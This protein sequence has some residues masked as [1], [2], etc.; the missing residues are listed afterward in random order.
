MLHVLADRRRIAR[1]VRVLRRRL[2]GLPVRGVTITWHGGGKAKGDIAWLREHAFWW[3]H[4][5]ALLK[6]RHWL[7]FGHSPD[8]PTRTETITC[9][10]NLLHAGADRRVAGA[11]LRDEDDALYLAH[12]GKIGGARA[13]RRKQ[14]FRDFA[15]TGNWQPARWPDG[16]STELLV[17]GP[18]EGPRLA[19]QVGRFV[20][21]VHGFKSGDGA[22]AALDAATP[23]PA[24][25]EAGHAISAACDRPLVLE[26]LAEELARRGL[27]ANGG[28]DPL[29]TPRRAA[30][31]LLEIAT[32]PAR[33]RIERA[34]GR[35]LL[36]RVGS[37]GA[38]AILIVPEGA[39]AS[40]AEAVGTAG[41][42]VVGYRW[43]AARPVFDGLDAALH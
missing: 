14:A 9:E 26:A 39:R 25:T 20:S 42:H 11:I 21:A 6:N 30:P 40:L 7:A 2:A 27:S 36:R 33:D 28:G 24:I 43:R 18:L 23:A 10:I 22:A 41:V 35:L 8:A 5:A 37:N 15:A 3:R 38:A 31:P 19:R 4:D 34:V 29:F 12:S 17:I 1:A 32:D 16:T 13:G